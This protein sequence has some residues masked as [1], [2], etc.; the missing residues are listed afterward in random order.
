MYKFAIY[1]FIMLI[2]AFASSQGKITRPQH[3]DQLV[4][5]SGSVENHSY[6]DLGLPSGTEWATCNMGA[7]K[8]YDF[9]KYYAWGELTPKESFYANG[10]F[11]GVFPDLIRKGVYPSIVNNSIGGNSKYDAATA[12]W[13]KSWRMP[14]VKDFEE[15][16]KYCTWKY[17]TI[18]GNNG[19]YVTGPNGKCIFLP[20][21]NGVCGK[22][23][24][25]L[26]ERGNYRTSDCRSHSGLRGSEIWQA[27]NFTITQNESYG[28]H[29]IF[30]DYP[31]TNGFSI[32][33]VTK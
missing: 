15:L 17:G 2:P 8:P 27:V 19:Y 32:R 3:I 20:L 10:T 26:N 6:V 23:N 4:I 31:E 29:R 30:G 16:N 14:S 28:D 1:I 13:G 18:N 22:D 7:S 21:A 12:Q 9:G 33:P 24:F 25:L 5:A 11:K